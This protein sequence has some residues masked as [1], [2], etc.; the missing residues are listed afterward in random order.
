MCPNSNEQLMAKILADLSHNIYSDG[1]AP[2]V[3][4]IGEMLGDI[5]SAM[6]LFTLPFAIIG[7]QAE[8]Y[9]QKYCYFLTKTYQKVPIDYQIKPDND[10]SFPIIQNLLMS[11]EKED[12][13]EL[14]SNLLASASDTRT[15]DKPHPSFPLVISQLS[16]IE[17]IILKILRK[18]SNIPFLE[19][20]AT[21]SDFPITPI[22]PFSIIPNYELDYFGVTAAFRNLLRL[23]LIHKQTGIL[24]AN[25]A[26]NS[27]ETIYASPI[28]DGIRKWKPTLY[29]PFKIQLEHGQLELLHGSFMAT[30]YGSRFISC[31][32]IDGDI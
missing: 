3:R 31:C 7:N 19:F 16:S 24:K 20:Q 25:S 28:F 10:I 12:I 8:K 6:T 21:G 5:T 29:S 18:E 27:F 2:A 22:E 13:C 9:R 4:N 26:Y 30:T 1:L 23:G 15:K 32:F 11:F 14:Y 17:A